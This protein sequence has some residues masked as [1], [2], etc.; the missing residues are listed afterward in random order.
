MSQSKYVLFVHAG[1]NELAR[2]LHA[3]LYAHEL[4]QVGIPSRLVFDGAAT[5]W[6][7]ELSNPEHKYHGLFRRVLD[8]GLVDAACAYC[9]NA[10]QVVEAVQAAGVPLV[11]TA[12]GHP[13]LAGYLQN[14][15]TP[16]VL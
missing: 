11:D 5:V 12:G 10:F 13:S 8:A 15:W 2:A 3:L 16:L 6:L 4:A 1:P 7:R 9:A 14:G